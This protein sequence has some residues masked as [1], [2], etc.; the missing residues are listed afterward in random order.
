MDTSIRYIKAYKRF[1]K[2]ISKGFR[3]RASYVLVRSTI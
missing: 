3:T 1:R 2:S